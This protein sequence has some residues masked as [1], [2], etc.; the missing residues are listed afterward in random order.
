MLAFRINPFIPE[1][2]AALIPKN[3]AALACQR[4]VFVAI[5]NIWTPSVAVLQP[6]LPPKPMRFGLHFLNDSVLIA[7][8]E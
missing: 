3:S 6:E 4:H 8:A 5:S 7:L 1:S 2:A